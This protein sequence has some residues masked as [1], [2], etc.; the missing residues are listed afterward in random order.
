MRRHLPRAGRRRRG[1]TLLELLLA[2]GLMVLVSVMLFVFYDTILRTRDVV[3]ETVRSGYLA[4]NIAQRMA[5]E[6]R[7]ANGFVNAAGPG[8]SGTDRLLT[9]Q[10][11]VIPDK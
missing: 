7:A 1:F 3:Q 5:E 4:R 6:I 10:T 9:I 2:L 11:V 8:I